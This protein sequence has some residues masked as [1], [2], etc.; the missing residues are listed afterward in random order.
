[1]IRDVGRLSDTINRILSLARLESGS[2]QG[3][4]VVSDMTE[5]VQQCC[6]T[7]RS[8]LQECDLLLPETSSEKIRCR[9]DRPLFDMLLVNLL[10]NAVKYN[11]SPRVRIAISL[12]RKRGRALM[13]VQ[14]NGI[15]LEERELKRIF[16]KFYQVE[17]STDLPANGSGLG[18]NLV[19]NIARLHRGHVWAESPGSGK[20]TTFSLS[21]PLVTEE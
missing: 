21:L 11:R 18:L 12:R 19:Q 16:N 2:Y 15:G 5:A 3:H 10:T 20:G 6:E 7:N 14:D 9:L 4:F 8:L 17:R 13:Q 1:M